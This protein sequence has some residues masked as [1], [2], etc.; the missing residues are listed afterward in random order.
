MAS[1]PSYMLSLLPVS[2]FWLISAWLTSFNSWLKYHFPGEKF[3]ISSFKMAPP[4][5]SGLRTPL[6]EWS[7]SFHYAVS[8][9]EAER[10]VLFPA[11]SAI[12]TSLPGL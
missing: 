7:A 3:L 12:S 11:V 10:S 8:S 5:H 1:G 6:L 4:S 9:M 2:H